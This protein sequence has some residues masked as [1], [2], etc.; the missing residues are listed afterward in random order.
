MPKIVLAYWLTA[1]LLFIASFFKGD[2]LDI[3]IHE[4]YL[5]IGNDQLFVLT[6]ILFSIFGLIAW[7]I[8]KTSKRLSSVLGWLHYGF[9]TISLALVTML[10]NKLK[11][12]SSV[13]RDYSVFNE[14]EEYESQES[15]SEWLVVIGAVLILSQLLLLINIVRAFVIKRKDDNK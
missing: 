3:A 4:T 13:Y 7:W 5:V 11:S 1:F 2:S 15:T 8:D 6:G 9:T 14:I 12:Q 10:A